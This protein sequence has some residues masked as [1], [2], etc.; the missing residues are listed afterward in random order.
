MATGN[1]AVDF[2]RDPDLNPFDLEKNLEGFCMYRL[3]LS[4]VELI[5]FYYNHTVVWKILYLKY[6]K[7]LWLGLDLVP[8]PALTVYKDTD[9]NPKRA[10]SMTGFK[11]DL[12]LPGHKTHWSESYLFPN[13][14]PLQPKSKKQNKKICSLQSRFQYFSNDICN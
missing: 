8:D 6:L 14:I 9:L 3:L 11:M 12:K 7:Y 2:D 4:H 13:V 5:P 1:P 10:P